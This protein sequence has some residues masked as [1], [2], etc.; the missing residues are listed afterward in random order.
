MSLKS[1]VGSR[2]HVKLIN[3]G[4]RDFDEIILSIWLLL[5]VPLT[6]YFRKILI[7]F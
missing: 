6:G 2:V 5:W 7:S 3:K 1:Q 4:E